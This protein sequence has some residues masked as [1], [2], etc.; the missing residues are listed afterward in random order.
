[1]GSK[2]VRATMGNF[3]YV[4]DLSAGKVRACAAQRM[5]S[6]YSCLTVILFTGERYPFG[7]SQ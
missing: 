4:V 5:S 7:G 2:V 6:H 3:S 1:M